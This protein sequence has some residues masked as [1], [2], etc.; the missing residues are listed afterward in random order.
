MTELSNRIWEDE[1]KAVTTNPAMNCPTY[2]K[3]E[4]A[5]KEKRGEEGREASV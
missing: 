2:W 1:A 4:E 5:H 3:K